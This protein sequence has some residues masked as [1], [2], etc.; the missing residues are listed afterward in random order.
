MKFV[1]FF[2]RIT[3]LIQQTH[4]DRVASHD[5][6]RPTLTMTPQ[7]QNSLQQQQQQQQQ[8]HLPPPPSP[9]PQVDQHKVSDILRGSN[10]DSIESLASNKDLLSLHNGA[11]GG[12]DSQNAAAGQEKIIRAFGELMRNMARMKTYI[13]P[14]MCKPYGKQSESLQKSEFAFF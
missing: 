10:I 13:R 7:L 5:V 11:W 12:Q 3:D 1:T 9:M 14:S 4:T 8:P 2:S 6:Q